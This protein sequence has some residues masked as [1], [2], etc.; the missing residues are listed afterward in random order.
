MIKKNLQFLQ[1]WEWTHNVR[2]SNQKWINN[3]NIDNNYVDNR[4]INL[5]TN[6]NNYKNI[7]NFFQNNNTNLFDNRQLIYSTD[8]NNIRDED[9]E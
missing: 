7:N 1:N 5:L 6:I 8:N 4:N 9:E 3:R 2:N